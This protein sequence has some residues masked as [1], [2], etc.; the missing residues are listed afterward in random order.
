MTTREPITGT[1]DLTITGTTRARVPKITETT[2]TKDRTITAIT[3]TRVRTITATTVT[4]AP[5]P[6]K[7]RWSKRAVRATAWTAGSAAFISALGAFGA[8]AVPV[9]ADQGSSSSP[10]H[11]RVI[12]RRIIK[13]IVIV[14][15][16][17]G[18]PVRV[19]ASGGVDSA[20]AGPASAPAPTTGGS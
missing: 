4:D 6:K 15:P 8:A 13:R 10:P 20:P 5:R 17:P 7:K 14:D 11:Q 12:V 3:G 19:V 18:A 2:R 9:A 16:A 1:R